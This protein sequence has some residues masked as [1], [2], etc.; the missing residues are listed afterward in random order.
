MKHKIAL[1]TLPLGHNYGGIIQNYALQKV[2][3]KMGHDVLTVNR[4]ADNP[5]SRIKVLASKYKSDFQRK[6]LQS[7]NPK[8]LPYNTIFK[9]NLS[10][11]NKYI[12]LSPELESTEAL[13]A[14]FK[15]E[16]FDDVIVGSDQV[17]RPKYSPDI[18][19]FYLDFIEGSNIKKL[20]Y[21]ASFGT[22]EWEYS[23]EQTKKCSE[24][25]NQFKAVSVRENSGVQISGKYLKMQDAI[26]ALDPT[27]LLEAEDYSQLIGEQQN[28]SGLFT[29]VLDDAEIKKDFI[30]SCSEYLKLE[31]STNQAKYPTHIYKS[32]KPEDYIVPSL[33]GW[34]QGFRDSD[35]VIT[36]SFHGTLFSIINKKQFL[37]LV[38]VDRGAS[39]FES[40]LKQL[41]LEDRLVYDV[42]KFDMAKLENG[43][44]YAEVYSKL[45]ILK[46][47][48]LNFLK[49]N[50]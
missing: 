48:S 16:K 31:V 29:Y 7:K 49:K 8:Y 34:L 47:H 32:D 3:S 27:L 19:N 13:I 38:N 18:F 28:R 23:N 21:A 41:G 39:R 42:K 43:I 40:I 44:D 14:Y 11:I 35:F 10:F 4:R 46:D 5:H 26:L 22:E 25:I 15:K 17:W 6:I 45:N 20:A 37:S 24:L 36:D 1:L 30:N 12:K 33:E 9:Q 50:I 2:L